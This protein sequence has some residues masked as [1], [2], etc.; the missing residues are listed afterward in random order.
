MCHLNL[1][2]KVVADV[3]KVK[4]PHVIKCVK[5]ECICKFVTID[6]LLCMCFELIIVTNSAANSKSLRV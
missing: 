5:Y 4:H 2:P 3:S 1:N 6:L